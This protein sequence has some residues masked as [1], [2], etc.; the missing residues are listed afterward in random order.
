MGRSQTPHPCVSWKAHVVSNIPVKVC[1]LITEINAAVIFASDSKRSSRTNTRY[2]NPINSLYIF[3]LCLTDLPKI[4]QKSNSKAACTHCAN[5]AESAFSAAT[6]CIPTCGRDMKNVSYA[7][8]TT[9]EINSG[10]H[11]SS[12]H[13]FS[14]SN[15]IPQLSKL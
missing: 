1:I 3:P 2:I 6:N 11:A 4:I 7:N 13:V 12:S 9:S 5:F 15:G 10:S 14:L 8:G